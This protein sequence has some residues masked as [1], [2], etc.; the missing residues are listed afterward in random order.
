[1]VLIKAIM[2]V[3]SLVSPRVPSRLGAVALPVGSRRELGAGLSDFASVVS[4][5][6]RHIV[7][8]S[9]SAA[10]AASSEAAAGSAKAPAATPAS[11]ADDLEVASARPVSAV[12]EIASVESTAEIVAAPEGVAASE[13]A[14]RVVSVEVRTVAAAAAS[15]VHVVVVPPLEVGPIAAPSV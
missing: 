9:V 2:I 12:A 11:A 7:V 3:W 14:S 8:F 6:E 13:S 4:M 10:A 5:V 1:M 15:V